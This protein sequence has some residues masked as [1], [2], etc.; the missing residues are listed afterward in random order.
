MIAFKADF[1]IYRMDQISGSHCTLDSIRYLL[2]VDMKTSWVID[3][4]FI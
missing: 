1:I 3:D 2:L 4:A